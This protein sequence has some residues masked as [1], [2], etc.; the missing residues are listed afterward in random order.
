MRVC[1]DL[2]NDVTF[3]FNQK[4]FNQKHFISPLHPKDLVSEDHSSRILMLY[5]FSTEPNL[6]YHSSEGYFLSFVASTYPCFQSVPMPFIH[7][8]SSAL[9][10]FPLRKMLLVLKGWPQFSQTSKQLRSTIC[11]VLFFWGV[12]LSWRYLSNVNTTSNSMLLHKVGF[13]RED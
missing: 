1:F 2:R 4:H 10:L 3:S 12:F 9:A 5:V 6:N 7:P 8:P 11:L 13:L